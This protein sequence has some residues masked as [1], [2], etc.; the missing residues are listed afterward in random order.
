MPLLT[1]L[2][3]RDRPIA[4]NGRDHPF[5]VNECYRLITTIAVTLNLLKRHNVGQIRH[6]TN[7]TRVRLWVVGP[8]LFYLLTFLLWFPLWRHAPHSFSARALGGVLGAM[9]AILMTLA[10][11]GQFFNPLG[12]GPITDLPVRVHEHFKD[13]S[14]SVDA[15]DASRRA[16]LNRPALAITKRLP[17]GTPVRGTCPLCEVEFSTEAFDRDKSYAHESK[18]EQQYGEHFQYHLS[19]DCQ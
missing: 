4:D 13:D 11:V 12:L 6:A 5:S 9:T 7:T 10:V 18:L 2:I 17:D 16:S 8:F 14:K 3:L 15:T 1:L 19:D